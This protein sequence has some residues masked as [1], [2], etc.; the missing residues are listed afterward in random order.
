MYPDVEAYKHQIIKIRHKNIVNLQ[1]QRAE[2]K[3]L[4]AE[5]RFQMLNTLTTNY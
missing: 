4:S 5:K 2:L 1:K 3:Q